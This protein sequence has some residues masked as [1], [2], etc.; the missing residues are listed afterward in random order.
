VALLVA[1]AARRQDDALAT[2]AAISALV[3]ERL[4]DR[5]GAAPAFPAARERVRPPRLTED[6]FC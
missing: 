3:H 4:G 6:W 2:F 1:T 5:S